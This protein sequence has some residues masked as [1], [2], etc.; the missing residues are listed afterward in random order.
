MNASDGVAVIATQIA[1]TDRRALSEAWYSALHLAHDKPAARS[2]PAQHAAAGVRPA[3]TVRVAP[4]PAHGERVVTLLP[5]RTRR[6]ANDRGGAAPE[7]RRPVNET[8][9][10][11]ERA[12]ERLSARRPVPAAHTL[13]VAGGRVRLLVH[14]DGKALRIVAVCSSP[15]RDVVER[16]LANARFAL[17]GTGVRVVAP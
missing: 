7:R 8:A 4:A 14:H 17:A 1:Q 12:V 13:D 5:T 11:I 9:R 15:L 10:R 2:S 3:P 6:D 16:A